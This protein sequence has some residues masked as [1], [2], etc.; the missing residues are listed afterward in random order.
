MGQLAIS[1]CQQGTRSRTQSQLAVCC[2]A[3]VRH[4]LLVSMTLAC[5]GRQLE[6]ARLLTAMCCVQVQIIMGKTIERSLVSWTGSQVH[7]TTKLSM[8]HASEWLGLCGLAT[9]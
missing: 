2:P 6:A 7:L 9:A 8:R 3:G 1:Y 5:W 4:I